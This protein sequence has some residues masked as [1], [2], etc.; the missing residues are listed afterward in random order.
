MKL[1]MECIDFVNTY[2]T[3]LVK[4]L[5]DDFTSQ[6]ICAELHMCESEKNQ[7]ELDICKYFQCQLI[8]LEF[9]F[10]T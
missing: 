2:A 9:C 1:Q 6:Q 7:G 10:L 4:M 5:S 3:E 8:F